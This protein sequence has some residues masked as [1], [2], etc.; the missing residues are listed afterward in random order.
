MVKIIII[1][2][3][4]NEKKEDFK[5]SSLYDIKKLFSFLGSKQEEVIFEE[6]NFRIPKNYLELKKDFLP[7]FFQ[8]KVQYGINDKSLEEFLQYTYGYIFNGVITIIEK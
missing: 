5:N 1:Q 2:E 7:S 3:S 8:N 4:Q 6:N